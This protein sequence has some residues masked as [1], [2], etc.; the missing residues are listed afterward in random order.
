MQ[1]LGEDIDRLQCAEVAMK[2][3][4][5]L[6]RNGLPR[7]QG[8]HGRVRPGRLTR[9]S[10]EPSEVRQWRP[11]FCLILRRK[12]HKPLCTTPTHRLWSDAGTRSFRLANAAN[13]QV[14]LA[15]ERIHLPTRSSS[16]GMERQAVI[17]RP[18]ADGRLVDYVR[19]VTIP[20]F[21]SAH[22]CC[23]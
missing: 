15:C 21:P 5:H 11:C 16:Q 14:L 12:P 13:R 22:P 17:T 6:Q 9:R 18:T 19:L 20:C 1:S 10:A 7:E 4:G 8:T 3:P 23:W 2:W